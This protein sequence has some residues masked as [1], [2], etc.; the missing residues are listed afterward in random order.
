MKINKIIFKKEKAFKLE[1]HQLKV[2][3]LPNRGGKIASIYN[4]TKKFELLYQNKADKYQPIQ[5]E[6]KFTAYDCSGFDDCFPNIDVAAL[7]LNQKLYFYPD[8]GEIWSAKLV[9][10]LKKDKIILSYHSPIFKYDYLKIITLHENRLL[11]NYQIKNNLKTAFP[12]IWTMHCLLNYDTN[13]KLKFPPGVNKI[14][15]VLL[16]QQL[17]PPG[18]IHSFPQTQDQIGQKYRFDRINY[19]PDKSSEK[20]YVAN[21]FE[22]GQ[23]EVYYPTADITFKLNFSAD[24][25]PYLGFW[26]T[27]GGFKG[28]YNF[29]FEPSDGY[30]DSVITALKNKCISIYQPGEIKQFNLKLELE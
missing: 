9:I 4:R 10:K 16:S 7:Y 24:K 15:N 1:N 14:E 8:H 21:C 23:C 29:A 11:I 12:A 25:L 18:K 5:L 20:Y 3:V 27:R 26:L 6:K 19:S 13:L 28:D 30:Y 22:S 2:I 17:G